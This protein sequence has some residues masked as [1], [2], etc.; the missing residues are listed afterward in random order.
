MTAQILL[1]QHS[2]LMS[3]SAVAP[4]VAEARG[5]FSAV[6]RHELLSLSFADWQARVPALVSPI[7][8]ASSTG[9]FAVMAP[10]PTTKAA[11]ELETGTA[12]EAGHDATEPL[13]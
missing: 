3:A 9:A 13:T 12:E 11:P 1:P 6:S 4:A 10:R 2:A 7:L 8:D 5:Y